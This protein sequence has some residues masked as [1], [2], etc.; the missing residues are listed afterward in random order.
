M[1]SKNEIFPS[2]KIKMQGKKFVVNFAFFSPDLQF[3]SRLHRRRE[4][5]PITFN[6]I[7]TI[8]FS[9]FYLL[10]FSGQKRRKYKKKLFST[11]KKSLAAVEF[12]NRSGFS[13]KK[14]YLSIISFW[15]LRTKNISY[16]FL[17]VIDAS[18]ILNV[19]PCT[20]ASKILVD[21]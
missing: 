14:W 21:W 13:R 2:M 17:D 11:G 6:Q 1:D 12:S 7:D 16:L 20:F 15:F 18:G 10:V 4:H 19:F 5:P 8:P 9:T 3:S